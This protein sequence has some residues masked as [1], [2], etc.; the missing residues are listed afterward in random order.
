VKSCRT[1]GE[2]WAF[3]KPK[4]SSYDERRKYL[5][6]AFDPLLTMLEEDLLTPGDLA[7]SLVLAKLDSEHIQAAW[8][9]A[10]DRRATDPEGAMTAARTL[11]ES[12]CKHILDESSISYGDKTDLPK[13]YSMAARQIHIAPSQ[14]TEKLFK[15]ILGGCQAVVEGLGALRSRLGD[16]H[17]KGKSGVKPAPRH[18]ELAVNLAGSMATF[19]IATWEVR[20]DSHRS[21]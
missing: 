10:L 17:G 2:F 3:I 21:R 15:Q 5:R 16:A 19:L 7:A 8:Q 12:V 18:A 13:L 1:I 11:I 9:T 6:E 14:H 20:R 4:F